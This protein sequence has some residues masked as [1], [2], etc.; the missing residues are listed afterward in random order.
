[1]IVDNSVYA[2]GYYLDNGIPIK[3]YFDDKNDSELRDILPFLRSLIGVEDVRKV[4]GPKFH[5]ES[6]INSCPLCPI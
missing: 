6:I 3:S 1:M 4:L 5:L 2:F